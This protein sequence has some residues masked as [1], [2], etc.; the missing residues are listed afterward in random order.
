MTH[1]TRQLHLQRSAARARAVAVVCA[2]LLMLAALPVANAQDANPAPATPEQ[3]KLQQLD[4]ARERWE[5]MTPDEREAV[6]ARWRELQQLSGEERQRALDNFRRL[7]SGSV[8]RD[9]S[10]SGAANAANSANGHN[11]GHQSANPGTNN[12]GTPDAGNH[13]PG[14]R[15]PANPFGDAATDRRERLDRLAPEIERMARDDM[16]RERLRQ[17]DRD[18]GDLLRD[19]AGM[20]DKL[21][22]MT[23]D[24]RRKYIAA[25]RHEGMRQRTLVMLR[26]C[27]IEGEQAEE[28]IASLEE[29]RR[30]E[31]SLIREHMAQRAELERSVIQR[32]QDE[33]GGDAARMAERWLAASRTFGGPD[34]R[35][36]HP[37]RVRG[38]GD[39][40]RGGSGRGDRNDRGDRGGEHD[41]MVPP[42]ERWQEAM[43]RVQLP[44]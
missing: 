37:D 32:M 16:Y 13:R 25:L 2:L 42:R 36:F 28:L 5:K 35:M 3:L 22:D 41:V 15:T 33:V 40:R 11:G 10:S 8:E 44:A 24:E 20:R 30:Q 18:V 9:G 39:P 23:S 31:D 14:P 19:D 29:Q 21:M 1:S 4:A 26:A 27:G 17:L 34:D 7:Q 38:G 43:D 6:T 12:A